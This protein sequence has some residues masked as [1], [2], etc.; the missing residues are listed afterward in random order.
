M[1]A[2]RSTPQTSTGES[3]HMMML[4]RETNMP[5]DVMMEQ[6]LPDQYDEIKSDYARDLRNKLFRAY[7]R[8]RHTLGK[9][10]V[11]QKT[12][13][14]KTA[15]GTKISEGDFVWLSRKATKRGMSKKLDM[16]WEGPYLVI[17][18]ISS[19]IY[20]IQ[21]YGPRGLQKVIHYDRLKPYCG[22]PLQSWLNKVQEPTAVEE[23]P[24]LTLKDPVVIADI[25]DQQTGRI[26][27]SSNQLNSPSTV[28][29]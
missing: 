1:L 15:A 28:D 24:V 27:P 8:V 23:E 7:E 19:V 16:K 10:A 4:G 13:H 2:Y 14:D 21:R 18:Q 17:K 22:K 26:A 3:P 11:R 5:I 12:N 25:Q 9:S 20:R 6:P 29:Q